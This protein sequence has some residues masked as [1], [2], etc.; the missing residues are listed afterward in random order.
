MSVRLRRRNDFLKFFIEKF[1]VRCFL[2][3]EAID[4]EEFSKWQDEVTIYHHQPGCED[5]SEKD[6]C[7]RSCHHR[8]VARQRRAGRSQTV[9]Q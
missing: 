8:E 9:G 4:P 1:D 5:P 6:I 7:H 2:C 3:G